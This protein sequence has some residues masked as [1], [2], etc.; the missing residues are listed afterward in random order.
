MNDD[1]HSFSQNSNSPAEGLE[2]LYKRFEAAWTASNPNLIEQFLEHCNSS[3]R[4]TV[5]HELLLIE[6][7]L[8]RKSKGQPRKEDYLKRFPNDTDTIENAFQWKPL[9]KKHAEYQLVGSGLKFRCPH[10]HNPI[11][12]IDDKAFLEIRCQACGSDLQ[13]VRDSES[14]AED[15]DEIA[16]FKLKEVIG[17]GAF[18]EVWIAYD[19]ILKR[20]VAVK[21]PRHS[22]LQPEDEEKFFREARSAAQL[23]HPHI[24]SVFEVGRD[25][26]RIFIAS[27]YITGIPLSEVIE[28]SPLTHREAAELC[29]KI[30]NALQHA[31]ERGIIHRDLKPQN[32]IID[33]EGEPKLTDFGLAKRETGEITMTLDGETIG[34]PAYMSPEQASG[35][36][37][38]ADA[39][40]DV[41][42][43]G[44]ILFELLTGELPFRGNKRMLIEQA[45]H[46]EPPSPR[47]LNRSVPKDL[48]TIILKCLEK[49]TARRYQ[50]AEL[51]S[52]ELSRWLKGKPI[53]ARPVSRIERGWRW[54]K[55]NRLA[56]GLVSV[57]AI[58]LMVGLIA[59]LL[60]ASYAENQA[61]I[62][63]T[64]NEKLSQ[65]N[66]QLVASEKQIRE[67]R[68]RAEV[69]AKELLRNVYNLS[70]GRA[71]Q[72][73][74]TNHGL[75][76]ALLENEVKCPPHLREITW[77]YLYHRLRQDNLVLTGHAGGGVCKLALSPDGRR[78]ASSD[79]ENTLK[80]WDAKT[81]QLQHSYE[82]G[83]RSRWP[84]IFS[85]DGMTLTNSWE[86]KQ[87]F[88]KWDSQGELHIEDVPIVGENELWYCYK[89]DGSLWFYIEIGNETKT[90]M[91]PPQAKSVSIGNV[92]LPKFDEQFYAW[93]SAASKDGSTVAYSRSDRMAHVY[94]LDSGEPIAF[95][96]CPGARHMISEVALSAD[97]KTVAAIDFDGKV[98]VWLLPHGERV[99]TFPNDSP[100]DNSL[101]MSE[102][103]KLIAASTHPSDIKVWNLEEPEEPLVL[104]GHAGKV[105]SMA[106]SSD[107]RTL[108][109]GGNDS[110]IRRWDLSSFGKD[111]CLVSPDATIG[112]TRF[113]SDGSIWS[114]LGDNRVVQWNV[115]QGAIDRK[116]TIE[117]EK[118]LTAKL[119]PTGEYFAISHPRSVKIWNTKTGEMLEELKAAT[120]LGVSAWSP[121]GKRWVYVDARQVRVR[122][123]P[124]GKELFTIYPS[125]HYVSSVAYSGDGNY[126]AVG[127]REHD[128]V[129]ALAEAAA[130]KRLTDWDQHTDTVGVL[131]FSNNSHLLASGD[132]SGYIC[133]WDI[134]SK[135]LKHELRAHSDRVTSLVFDKTDETLISGSAGGKYAFWDLSNGQQ[136][137]VSTVANAKPIVSLSLS[138][139]GNRLAIATAKRVDFWHIGPAND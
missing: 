122:E 42:S 131:A 33:D 99:H 19:T 43:L 24:V 32:I 124:T 106:L 20:T 91:L 40:T 90:W 80:I 10:C 83:V 30:A 38:Q 28:A 104:R 26:E 129:I 126:I 34:T 67:A 74:D 22:S 45:I 65:A 37:H 84:P 8:L 52:E 137:L 114:T 115:E 16:H 44:V 72:L 48:E 58:S 79:R 59:S 7:E 97:G 11:E 47:K 130:G 77:R 29:I 66:Q 13:L 101:V 133:I 123:I 112:S 125:W 41:Y 39:T 81:G 94:D 102:D 93:D 117:G 136:R 119:S 116:F 105:V 127:T 46:D 135:E 82:N 64:Q 87:R 108:F 109:S 21:I 107:K 110:T 62:F 1:D 88:W 75:A 6:F 86:D 98:S 15:L 31:H 78:L 55:N 53:L 89:P 95:L 18:G 14:Y 50:S 4:T 128:C 9:E 54:C 73:A 17:V 23:A 68:D 27:E 69:N 3:Q 103:G 70:L 12:L 132:D 71:S 121:D 51:L 25:K 61:K 60:F 63:E 113:A 2:N 100:M 56:A 85:P 96:E 138:P 36:A 134:E 5:L 57:V 92:G 49:E 76:I 118:T 111:H 139:D 120:F 35:E